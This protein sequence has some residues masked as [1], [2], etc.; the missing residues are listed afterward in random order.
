MRQ[1][2]SPNNYIELKW[3]YLLQSQTRLLPIQHYMV[4][5]CPEDHCHRRSNITMEKTESNIHSIYAPGSNVKYTVFVYGVT[6]HW[7]EDKKKSSMR[8]AKR[9]LMRPGFFGNY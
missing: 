9:V 6:Y 5:Y 4:G 1:T 3:D 2:D 8:Q 7:N